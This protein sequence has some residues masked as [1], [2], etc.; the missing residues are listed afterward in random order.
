MASHR[1]NGDRSRPTVFGRVRAGME[2]NEVES[3]TS[4]AALCHVAETGDVS[5]GSTFCSAS[6]WPATRPRCDYLE[7]IV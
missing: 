5:L 2:T 4:L 3:S 1:L 6:S 7:S